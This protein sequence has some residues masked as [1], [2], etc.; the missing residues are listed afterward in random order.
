MEE[1]AFAGLDL[2][3]RADEC[4]PDRL[5]GVLRAEVF[6]KQDLDAAGGIGRV[7]LGVQAGP[8]G[9]EPGR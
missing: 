9:V 8:G 7:L 6:R 1:E 2:A 4:S 5:A 3:A